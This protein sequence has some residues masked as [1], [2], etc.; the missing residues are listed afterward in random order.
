MFCSIESII[1]LQ[2]RRMKVPRVF[3][4]IQITKEKENQ[5]MR[6]V[7]LVKKSIASKQHHSKAKEKEKQFWIV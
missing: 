6:F 3:G 5:K 7:L 4:V 1:K 2:T